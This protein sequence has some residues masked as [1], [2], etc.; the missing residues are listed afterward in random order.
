MAG[1]GGSRPSVFEPKPD[2]H[3]VAPDDAA[4]LHPMVG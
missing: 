3:S 1:N 2:A 4:G